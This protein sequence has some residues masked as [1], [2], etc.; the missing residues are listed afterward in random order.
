[1]E[2]SS[3]HSRLRNCLVT[4]LELEGTLAT[5]RLGPALQD[6]F[7]TLKQIVHRL[8]NIR[9]EESDVCRIEDVTTRFLA[10]LK[11]TL[12]KMEPFHFIQTGIL[13]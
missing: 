5:T 10:E 2:G 9:T 8:E 6:D 12:E 7:D 11:L 3:L 13:Q 1:M 4:I